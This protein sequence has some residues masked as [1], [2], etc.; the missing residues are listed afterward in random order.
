MI[1]YKIAWTPRCTEQRQ[2]K[3]GTVPDEKKQITQWAFYEYSDSELT[4]ETWETALVTAVVATGEF[5]TPKTDT[6]GTLMRWDSNARWRK[7]IRR[8]KK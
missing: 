4:D 6:G 2:T 5:V 8:E 1:P 3:T 7:K